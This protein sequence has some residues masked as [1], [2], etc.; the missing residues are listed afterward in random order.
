MK[1]DI[2]TKRGLGAYG[3]CHIAVAK[4]H[5]RSVFSVFFMQEFVNIFYNFGRLAPKIKG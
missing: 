4:R 2:V 5:V 3:K 1:E